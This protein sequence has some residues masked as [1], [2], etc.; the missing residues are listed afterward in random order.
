MR[1]WEKNIPSSEVK[2]ETH[3]LK[4]EWTISHRY[5]VNISRNPDVCA[6][7]P[8]STMKPFWLFTPREGKKYLVRNVY[9][10]L[11]PTNLIHPPPSKESVM[12]NLPQLQMRMDEQ[13][14]PEQMDT[15]KG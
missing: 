11:T 5:R 2:N 8:R 12:A 9:F 15:L 14:S 6:I 4:S 1:I 10:Y 13:L 7:L 3:G